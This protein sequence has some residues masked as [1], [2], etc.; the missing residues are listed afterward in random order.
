MRYDVIVVGSGFTGSV[1]ARELANK[2]K[3]VLLVEKRN[4]IAGNMYDKKLENGV[5]VHIYGPHTFFTDEIGLVKYIQRFSEWEKFD[6]KAQV[7]ID[8]NNYSLPF[9]FRFVSEYF[10][11]EKAERLISKLRAM[12]P[13]QERA[14]IYELLG[15]KDAE[16]S[17]LGRLLCEKDYYPYASKQWGIP[18]ESLD[19]SVISRVKFALSDDDRYIQQKYQYV[20]IAGYT[21]FFERLLDSENIFIYKE[22]DALEHIFFNGNK[23]YFSWDSFKYECPIVFTGP[24]DELF[25]FK[26]G[27]LP[28]R[29]L[30]IK[31]ESY[32]KD[33][34]FDAAFVSYPQAEGYT[35]KVEYKKITAQKLK[36]QTTISIEYPKEYVKGKNLPFYPVINKE[37]LELLG[38]YRNEAQKYKNLFVCGRLGD[39]KY[40]NMDAAVKRALEISNE[41]YQ[42]IEGN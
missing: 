16:I 5:L 10:N 24:I 29:S 40:Y 22:T 3:K 14:T 36:G 19:P 6:V 26:F 35:R 37:N 11:C 7:C 1:I 2:N 8:D 15:T 27:R 13:G 12:F 42:M 30:D 4:H 31:F 32:E 9:G 39:Y 17:E 41:I 28:Y 34:V 20:P 38:S 33:S 23:A 21:S 25:S 18:M